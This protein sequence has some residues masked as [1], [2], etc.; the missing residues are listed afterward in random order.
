MLKFPFVEKKSFGNTTCST[1]VFGNI[2]RDSSKQ[3]FCLSDTPTQKVERCGT[4][5]EHS[6][7][8][9]SGYVYYGKEVI[10]G[11]N[12][13]TFDQVLRSGYVKKESH[14]SMMCSNSAFGSD[15]APGFAK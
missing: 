5:R 15:P 13:A 11:V 8:L 3:C 1:D 10:N 4:E 9:G 2:A 14:G 7:C 6:E 12:P